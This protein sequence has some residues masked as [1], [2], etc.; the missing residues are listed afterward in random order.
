MEKHQIIE[1]FLDI[2]LKNFVTRLHLSI[3]L[4]VTSRF[5][6]YNMLYLGSLLNNIH[7]FQ[8]ELPLKEL[9]GFCHDGHIL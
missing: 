1:D 5:C 8:H 4:L 9:L 2:F 6:H 7:M 3:A